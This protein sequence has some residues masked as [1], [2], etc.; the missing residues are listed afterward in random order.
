VDAYPSETFQGEV[1][2]IRL[3]ATMTQNVVTYTFEVTTDNSSGKLLPYLTA[4]VKFLVSER[5]NVLMAPNAA[6]RFV[7][8]PD[9]IDPGSRSELK[10]ETGA[11]AEPSPEGEG[12]T[13]SALWIPQGRFVRQVPIETGLS[14]GTMTEIRDG[15]VL[16]LIS[17]R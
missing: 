7:P 5:L 16:D 14:D 4:D 6:L 17:P 11:R 13:R 12:Y 8:Q 3:N 15:F 9:L 2:K 10:V 1:G